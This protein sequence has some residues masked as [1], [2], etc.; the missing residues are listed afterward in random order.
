VKNARRKRRTRDDERLKRLGGPYVPLSRA[1]WYLSKTGGGA[2][3]RKEDRPE[4]FGCRQSIVV[5]KK[6]DGGISK[7]RGLLYTNERTM[8]CSSRMLLR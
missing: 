5:T 7:H 3:G 1:G 8:K 2:I 4:D 6:R